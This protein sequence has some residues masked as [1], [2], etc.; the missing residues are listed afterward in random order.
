MQNYNFFSLY[1]NILIWLDKNIL[2]QHVLVQA[3]II[4]GVIGLS[5]IF[6]RK[7]VQFRCHDSSG[8]DSKSV[9]FSGKDITYI[10]LFLFGW[11][12]VCFAKEI[13]LQYHLIEIFASIAGASGIAHFIAYTVKSYVLRHMLIPIVWFL[14]I[15]RILGLHDFVFHALS[16]ASFTLG[17]LKV[18]LLSIGEGIVTLLLM[19]WVAKMCSAFLEKRIM[20]AGQLTSAQKIIF[21]KI[22]KGGLIVIALTIAMHVMGIDFAALTFFSGAFGIGL[23]FGLQKPISNLVSGIILALDNSIKPGDVMVVGGKR[24]WINSIGV[25]HVSIVTD[26][27]VEHLIPNEILMTSQVENWSYSNSNVR[28]HVSVSI[29]HTA[30]LHKACSL[31]MEVVKAHPRILHDPEPSCVLSGFENAGLNL[32]LRAWI[33]DP[34]K[35][36]TKLQSDILFAAWE[37]FKQHGIEISLPQLDVYMKQ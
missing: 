28:I 10:M 16:Q 11:I 1:E 5:Y 18:S 21:C 31:L 19:V 7:L 26:D 4:G 23:G 15:L 37:K 17:S 25:R 24:G 8:S 29:A 34:I 13:K 12:A 36:I 32:D 22:M 14:A 6:S 9:F 20:L 33:N 30:D 35:G 27:G 3:A 2:A